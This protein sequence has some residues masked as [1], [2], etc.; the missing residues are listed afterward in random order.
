[1][2][3]APQKAN[4]TLASK[5]AAQGLILT[6]AEQQLTLAEAAERGF[7]P[8]NAEQY[9]LDGIKA[10]FD[11][12]ISR[13]PATYAYPTAANV[14][15][16]ASY[17][18]QPAVA[19][20]GSKDEKLAKI[21]LQK[22]ISLYNCGFE[23]WSEWRRTGVPVITAGPASLGFVPV[24]FIYPLSEQNANKENYTAAV[25]IQGADKTTTHVWWDVQ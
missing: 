17:Y 12:Y 7:I 13:I 6:Y 3:W 10:H 16:A 23:G 1:M 8:G 25:A 5:T 11:Y 2:I 19:Y 4:P 24:R 9:Y 21:H 20:T 22:W 14:T 18:T 15:P